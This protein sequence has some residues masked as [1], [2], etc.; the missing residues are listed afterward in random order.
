MDG[1]IS[2]AKDY[3]KV[4]NPNIKSIGKSKGLARSKNKCLIVVGPYI[5][6]GAYF[7]CFQNFYSISRKKY[8]CFVGF[9]DL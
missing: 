4:W 6:D 7:K 5:I 8:D 1:M 2:T 9:T 3:S